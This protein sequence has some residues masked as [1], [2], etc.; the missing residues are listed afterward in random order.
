MIKRNISIIMWHVKR[1]LLTTFLLAGFDYFRNDLLC[2]PEHSCRLF[3]S[4]YVAFN[5]VLMIPKFHLINS[6]NDSSLLSFKETSN[7]VI[8]EH[9]FRRENMYERT[10]IP[11]K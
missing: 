3:E 8:Y 7:N 4:R 6:I 10:N 5:I 11:V 9:M 2:L 1:S